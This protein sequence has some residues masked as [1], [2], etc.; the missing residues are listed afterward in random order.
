MTGVVLVA[1][2]RRRNSIKR[3]KGGLRPDDG[4]RC[5]DGVNR[6]TLLSDGL[7]V[8]Q[9]YVLIVGEGIC[10]AVQGLLIEQLGFEQV[11]HS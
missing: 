9:K 2:S 8:L 4:A 11:T 5:G 6:T 3:N 1:S 10:A 7:P